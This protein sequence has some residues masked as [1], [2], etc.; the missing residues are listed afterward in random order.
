[1]KSSVNHGF[2]LQVYNETKN[3]FLIQHAF[4]YLKLSHT[5]Q[6][7]FSENNKLLPVKHFSSEYSADIFTIN[8]GIKVDPKT[9]VYTNITFFN[10]LSHLADISPWDGKLSLYFYPTHFSRNYHS[11]QIR[12]M[13]GA[14]KRY[15]KTL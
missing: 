1:M 13:S 6:D 5:T 15:N 4:K 8:I 3:K 10:L 11:I 14:S 12:N 7:S 9:D 2:V